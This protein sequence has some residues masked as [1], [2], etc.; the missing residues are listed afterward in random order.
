MDRLS[1]PGRTT[2]RKSSAGTPVRSFLAGQ[3]SLTPAILRCAAARQP[4]PSR[5]GDGE[6]RARVRRRSPPAPRSPSRPRWSRARD[7]QGESDM[8]NIGTFKKSGQEF[9]GE[10]VT[11]SVQTKGVG[12]VPRP[13]ATATPPPA[14][15]SMSAAPRSAP[16]GR[17]APTRVATTSRSSSTTRAST[18]S[19]TPT[20]SQ[21]SSFLPSKVQYRAQHSRSF[22]RNGDSKDLTVSNDVFGF[23]GIRQGHSPDTNVWAQHQPH[24]DSNHRKYFGSAWSDDDLSVVR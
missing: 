21:L 5:K 9:F 3:E 12:I 22:R 16:P 19:S 23:P 10:I 15:A 1:S 13:A 18:R 8:A 2:P 7:Q 17:S 14:T 4:T 11:L 24:N 6:P 20:S